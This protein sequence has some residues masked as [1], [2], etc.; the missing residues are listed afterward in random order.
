MTIEICAPDSEEALCLMAEMWREIDLLYGNLEPSAPEMGGMSA[1]GSAFLI[2][3]AGG[4]AAGC[5]GLRPLSAEIAEVKRMYV[6]PAARGTGLAH[7]LM[8]RLEGVARD[9]GFR[10]LWLETGLRQ[11]AA[12]RLYERLGYKRIASYGDYARDALSVCYGR[13]LSVRS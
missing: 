10:E 8:E 1:A 2:A 5:V 13:Q 3:R 12:I 4:D 11:P 9:N 6:R 7:L